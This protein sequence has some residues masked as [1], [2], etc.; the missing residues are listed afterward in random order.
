MLNVN[1]KMLN[2]NCKML[3]DGECSKDRTRL[4]A[5][6]SEPP[7]CRPTSGKNIIYSFLNSF[8]FFLIRAIKV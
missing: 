8:K 7:R 4:S 6:K 5:C 2:V 1:C 3:P